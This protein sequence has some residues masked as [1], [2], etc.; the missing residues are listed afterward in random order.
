PGLWFVAVGVAPLAG[1]PTFGSGKGGGVVWYESEEDRDDFIGDLAELVH[2]EMSETTMR[3]WPPCL[4]HPDTM[5]FMLLAKQPEG[6]IVWVCPSD[7]EIRALFGSYGY[8]Q[9]RQ[10]RDQ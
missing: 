3:P 9:I 7:P 6:E 2:D 10:P 8:G 5:E 4:G 1:Q